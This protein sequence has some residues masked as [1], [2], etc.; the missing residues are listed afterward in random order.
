M[1]KFAVF[2]FVIIHFLSCKKQETKI[3]LAVTSSLLPVFEAFLED[4]DSK[5]GEKMQLIHSSS[6]KLSQQ[7]VNAAPYATFFSASDIY[8]QF[9]KKELKLPYESQ[10]FAKGKLV[11]VINKKQLQNKKWMQ[12]SRIGIANPRLAPYGE[13]AEIYLK[14]SPY[15][16]QFKGK[17]IYGQNVNQVLQYL[18]TKNI[19]VGILS[20]ANVFSAHLDDN[21]FEIIDLDTHSFKEIIHTKL[22]LK[23]SN[24]LT[25]FLSYLKS[26]AAKQILT[27]YGYVPL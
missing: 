27:T 3:Q 9:V 5:R 2:F 6:G 20:K 17:L 16:S 22:I 10:P 23:P 1:E 13:L 11:M 12:A 21:I 15:Y 4:Y 7:I 25:H 14:A 19:S 18:L 24:H 8:S 26:D